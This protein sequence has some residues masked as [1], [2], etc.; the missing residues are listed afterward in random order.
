LK[1]MAGG[2]ARRNITVNVAITL[3]TADIPPAKLIQM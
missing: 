1:V 2:V 3:Q